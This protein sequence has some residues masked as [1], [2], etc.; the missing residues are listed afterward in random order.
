[1]RS[2]RTV[3]AGRPPVAAAPPGVPANGE[4]RDARSAFPGPTRGAGTQIGPGSVYRSESDDES[5]CRMAVN[6]TVRNVLVAGAVAAAAGAV[7]RDLPASLG[8]RPSGPRA[9]RVRR[10]PNFRDGAFHNPPSAAAVPIRPSF[11]VVVKQLG[12]FAS[13]RPRGPVPL[14]SAVPEPARDGLRATWYGHS[15]V[16]LEIEGRRVLLDP[17]WSRRP[18][19]VR[20]AGPRRLHPAPVPL[21]A[22]PPVDAVVI[23][24]DHYDH[25]DMPTV[26]ALC[27]TQAARFVVPLGIGGHLERWGVP[28][29]RIVELD[30]EE[31]AKVAGLR[32]VATAARHFSGR[33]LRRNDTLWGSWAIIGHRHRAFY[34]GDSGYFDGFAGIGAAHGPFDL[35]LMPIGAYSALWPDVHMTPEEAVTAHLDLG[36]RLLLPVHWATFNLAPH[37]WAEPADRLWREAKSCGVDVTVPRPGEPVD[38]ASPPPVDGWWQTLA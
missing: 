9:E 23:S 19:P 21:D 26:R 6:R 29:E 3:S 36:G 28:S 32:F 10:S 17:I 1:M 38:V 7:L 15:S 25:L 27:R 2:L 31:E 8:R 35:T 33:T 16:L 14:V 5:G 22:L 13:R 20:F 18:S 34:A 12:D 11:T 24:H 30:W 37:P 4:A